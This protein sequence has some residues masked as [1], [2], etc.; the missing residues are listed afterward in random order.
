MKKLVYLIMF[1]SSWG[2]GQI[3]FS[4]SNTATGAGTSL[5]ID[6]TVASGNTLGV[7]VI[8]V[9]ATGINPTSVTDTQGTN[10]T[11]AASQ[12]FNART[13]IYYSTDMSTTGSRTI[14]VNLSSSRNIAIVGSL[15]SGTLT[16]SVLVQ[17]ASNSSASGDPNVTFT[18]TNSDSLIIFGVGTA[19]NDS[20]TGYGSGQVEIGQAVKGGSPSARVSCSATYEI[21]T[22][23]GSNDQT[24]TPFAN[25]WAAVVAEFEAAEVVAI[26]NNK[27]VITI[28]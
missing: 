27:R 4:S 11:L 22:S 6:L 14:T 21:I 13:I 1:V 10:W 18:P 5:G 12:I 3:T 26:P 24:A 25:P 8:E 2:F 9:D 20:Y 7:L 28:N 23:G 16:S 17:T 19:E 15:Y